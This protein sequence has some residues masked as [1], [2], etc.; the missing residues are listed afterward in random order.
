MSDPLNAFVPGGPVYL[1]GAA[2]GPLSGLRF[3]A[4]DIFDV[5]GHVT[6]GGNPDWAA[7]HP[8]ATTTAPVVTALLAAGANLVGKTMTDE[9]TRGILAK[10]KRR[11]EAYRREISL[12][13]C[14]CRGQLWEAGQR[15]K[16]LA[17]AAELSRV[18]PDYTVKL[19]A[20]ITRTL[21]S[22]GTTESIHWM[23]A[24]GG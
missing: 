17:S 9:L 18:R 10:K 24:H 1:E 16:A 19:H 8:P 4:K 6:G 22:F 7:T 14:I 11:Q 3:A 15:E 5:A 12:A 20:R 21:A 2:T 23:Y 13:S